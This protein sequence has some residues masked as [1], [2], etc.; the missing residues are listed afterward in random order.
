[1]WHFVLFCDDVLQ[2][3]R[4]R[5]RLPSLVRLCL[6]PPL[7][8]LPPSLPSPPLRALPLLRLTTRAC[9][10]RAPSS[11]SLRRHSGGPGWARRSGASPSGWP[12][13]GRRPCPALPE[14]NLKPSGSRGTST[15]AEHARSRQAKA[16]HG[17]PRR[18]LSPPSIPVPRDDQAHADRGG[19]DPSRRA[20]NSDDG[21]PTW[22][23]AGPV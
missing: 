16:D 14:P 8:L 10:A 1:M 4:R 20:A 9:V 13:A 21:V 2:C 11:R 15:A 23:E 3:K 19:Q 5:P 7:F 18:Q 6:C 22:S 12:R 17:G